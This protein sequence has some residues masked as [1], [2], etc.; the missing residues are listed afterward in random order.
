MKL[1]KNSNIKSKQGITLKKRTFLY[2]EDAPS[3]V[4]ILSHKEKVLEFE[5]Y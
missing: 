5:K 3:D 4:E 1:V 2:I